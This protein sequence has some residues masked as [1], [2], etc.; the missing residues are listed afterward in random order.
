[1]MRI[2]PP[3]LT[4]YLNGPGGGSGDPCSN[5]ITI[6]GLGS[7]NAKTFTGGSGGSWNTNNANAC[8]YT[9]PGKEQVYQ[10]SV[11]TTGIYSLTVSTASGGYVDFLWKSNSCGS[12]GWSC[13][14][15][16]NSPGTFGNMNWSAGQVIYL[17][18]DDENTSTG[19]HTFYLNGSGGGSCPA[20]YSIFATSITSTSAV[21]NFTAPNA[22][23]FDYYLKPSYASTY[24]VYSNYT[25]N[26]VQFN[27]L[28]PGT[29]YNFKVKSTAAMAHHQ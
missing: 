9:C 22:N 4:F 21:L 15:D 2:L 1:M 13:I 18:V 17:L 10:Y 6:A 14:D 20:P 27:G 23:T 26:P 24:T 19:N 8:G 5:V 12:T 28:I 3:V 25:F 29:T 11:P 16:V 7:S